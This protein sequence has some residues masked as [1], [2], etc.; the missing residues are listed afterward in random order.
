MKE[1]NLSTI[2]ITYWLGKHSQMDF[3]TDLYSIIQVY[4]IVIYLLL[5]LQNFTKRHLTDNSRTTSTA[6]LLTTQSFVVTYMDKIKR[7]YTHQRTKSK[8]KN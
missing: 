5:Y 4:S 1:K 3:E 7:D 8:I 6:S 2:F